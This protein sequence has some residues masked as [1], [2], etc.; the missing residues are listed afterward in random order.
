MH[1]EKIASNLK[2]SKKVLLQSALLGKA[3]KVYSALSVHQSSSYDAVKGVILLVLE[4]YRQQFQGCRKDESQTYVEFIHTK[5]NL[6][7]H[8]CTAKD[9]NGE[10]TKLQL[11]L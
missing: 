1:F 9:I 11:I 3:R 5:E 4:T 10:F 8:W 7:A 6:F 2:W